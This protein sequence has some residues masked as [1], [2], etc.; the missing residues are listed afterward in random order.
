MG[1]VY[2]SSYVSQYNDDFD[3]THFL[4][5]KYGSFLDDLNR[6]KLKIPGDCVCQWSFFCYILF[7]KLAQVT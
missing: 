2:M 4:Y 3:D 7:H 6:S 1:L 5:L